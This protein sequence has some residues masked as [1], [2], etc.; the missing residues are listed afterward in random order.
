MSRILPEYQIKMEMLVT[1]SRGAFAPYGAQL[2]CRKGRRNGRSSGQDSVNEETLG[3]TLHFVWSP[4][5]LQG[6]IPSPTRS[7][8]FPRQCPV[9]SLL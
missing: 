5:P 3:T 9:S 6:H 7:C 8:G 1:I 4:I 2:G